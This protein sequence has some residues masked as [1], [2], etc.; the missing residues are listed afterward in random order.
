MDKM[1][2]MV[3][4]G[5]ET[6]EMQERDIPHPKAGEVRV[7][8]A[9]TSVCGSDLGAYKHPNSRFQPP[10]VLGHE[11]SG[12]I[13]EIGEGV[14]GL[15]VGQHICGNPPVYCGTCWFCKNGHYNICP[16][17]LSLGN[18]AGVAKLDGTYT[19]YICLPAFCMVPLPDDM[20]LIYGS[21]MEPL[22][23]GYHAALNGNFTKGET[24]MVIGAGPIGLLTFLSLRAAGAGKII[25]SDVSEARL[26]LAKQCGADVIINSANEDP[27]EVV[28]K[29]TDGL[30]A[31]RTIL[32]AGVPSL[33][34][35]S[36]ETTRNCGDVVLV[37][38]V[39]QPVEFLPMSI[40]GRDVNI[41]SSYTFTDEIYESVKMVSEGKIDL[42]PLISSIYSLENGPEAFAS[43][44]APGNSEV[45]VVIDMLGLSKGD[46]KWVK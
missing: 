46:K 30:R 8:I 21:M 26:A 37:G 24:T 43:L 6:M 19:E 34:N 22:S 1:K 16:N 38:M 45:K 41:I 31:D 4:V 13:D 3:L 32:C 15:E 7:K 33:F 18:S 17:R 40:F 39:Q 42:E 14:E 12:I 27:V 20:P 44:A 9:Y 36:I 23:V 25:V 10:I 35:Q 11:Y 29:E 2:A 5:P 28:K